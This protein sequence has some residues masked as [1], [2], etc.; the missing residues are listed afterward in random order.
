MS[1]TRTRP[2]GY[3]AIAVA[4]VYAFALAALPAASRASSVAF[5]NVRFGQAVAMS[6]R[7]VKGV[8][9]ARGEVK[10]DGGTF[11][12]VEIAVDAVLK[13]PP[14]KPA[15]RIR[16]FSGSEWFQHTHAAAIKAG[17]VSY[18]DPHYATPIADAEIKPGTAVIAFLRGEAPPPGF[19]ANA[20]FLSCGE[21]YER[22]E[23]A[24]DVARI[25]TAAF[26]D[27]ITL[28]MGEVA[29]LPDGLELEVKGHTHKRPM[30]GGPQREMTELEARAATRSERF[31]LGHDIDPGTPPQP[32]K[33]TWQ[34]RAWQQYEL[35]LVGMKYGDET[36][37]RVVRRGPGPSP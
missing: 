22:P 14:A 15:E 9:K 18:A 34:R 20:A 26:G 28:K 17:V 3:G 1:A 4:I 27:P 6:A 12:T 37:L 33:E 13:G 32:A 11:H 10:V 35:A 7:V 31:V 36:T 25:K 24:A 19:P 5:Q 30:T 21:A 8:V 23:R 16:V 2:P 29:V